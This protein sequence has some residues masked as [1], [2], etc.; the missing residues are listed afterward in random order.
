MFKIYVGRIVI[1]G[2][3][4]VVNILA[5]KIELKTSIRELSFLPCAAHSLNLVLSCAAKITFETVNFFNIVQELYTYFSASPYRWNILKRNIAR[6]TL[7][8]LSN[9]RWEGRIKAVRPL[10]LQLS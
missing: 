4:C 5:Y 8:S 6:L 10:R 2:Q 9:T 1:T 7:K 3:T